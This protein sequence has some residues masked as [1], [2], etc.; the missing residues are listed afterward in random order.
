[1]AR[2]RRPSRTR[3]RRTRPSRTKSKRTSASNQ[4]LAGNG[5]VS[6]VKLSTGQALS[7]MSNAPIVKG[8]AKPASGS[9]KESLATG[10]KG[11]MAGSGIVG[12]NPASP[13]VSN[14]PVAPKRPLLNLIK[15]LLTPK[16]PIKTGG[17]NSSSILEPETRG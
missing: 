6:S 9:V 1:M 7:P 8:G 4:Q 17:I 3:V 13:V 11:E 16:V 12:R 2:R 14:S 10:H 15:M 5:K